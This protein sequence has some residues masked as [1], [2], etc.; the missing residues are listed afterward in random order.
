MNPSWDLSLPLDP[1]PSL[2]LRTINANLSAAVLLL[3]AM[4]VAYAQ[5]LNSVIT[6]TSVVAIAL[7]LMTVSKHRT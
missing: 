6:S 4:V 5:P 1:I 3:L 2:S 7:S